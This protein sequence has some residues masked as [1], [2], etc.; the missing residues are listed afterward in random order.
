MREIGK[1]LRLGPRWAAYDRDRGGRLVHAT[2][3]ERE[4]IEWAVQ[5]QQ[6]R[7]TR[8]QG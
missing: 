6:W 8:R 5:N 2:K 3:T 1:S 7:W 4:A